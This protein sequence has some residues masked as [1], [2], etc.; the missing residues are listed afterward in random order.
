MAE[1]VLY[2]VVLKYLSQ[3]TRPLQ[4]RHFNIMCEDTGSQH[5]AVPLHTGVMWLLRG[6]MSVRLN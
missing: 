6:R 2:R 5:I 3:I 1:E 4:S